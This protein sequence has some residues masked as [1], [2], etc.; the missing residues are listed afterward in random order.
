MPINPKTKGAGFT[1][2]EL[3]VAVA[4]FAILIGG[5]A[6]L[7][8]G[9]HLSALENAKRVK[10]G[11][12]L[13]ETW[14][15]LHAIRNGDFTQITNGTHGLSFSNGYWEFYSDSDERDN[16]TRRVTV[17][18]V[19]RDGNSDIVESGGDVDSDSKKILIEISWSPYTGQN[20]SISVNTYL[21]NYPNPAPWPPPPPPP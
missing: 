14:E 17:T 7:I 6:T 20:Q 11:A 10:A 1:L 2:V 3:V 12:M 9:S 4:I 5:M 21:H 15:A 13:S 16:I 19:R 18:D 8:T